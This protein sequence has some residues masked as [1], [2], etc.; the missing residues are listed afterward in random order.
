MLLWTSSATL[1]RSLIGTCHHA[2][3]GFVFSVETGSHYVA[4][5]GLEL[6]DSSDPPVLAF[7]GAA[8]TEYLQEKDLFLWV[9][10]CLGQ[11]GEGGRD[12]K[13]LGKELTHTGATGLPSRI[14]LLGSTS[15]V[16]ETEA[17]AGQSSTQ[18]HTAQSGGL[19]LLPRLAYS[20]VIMAQCSLHLLSFACSIPY[21]QPT[22]NYGKV[23]T[24]Q[25]PTNLLSS[26]NISPHQSL[27]S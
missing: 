23:G 1:T 6:L 19:T 26:V 12:T 17:R 7:K 11:P 2:W 20:S 18:G 5:A 27:A 25:V 21:S 15:T 13:G 14:D 4:K 3:L 24:V 16:E 8:N 9:L 10:L 22:L